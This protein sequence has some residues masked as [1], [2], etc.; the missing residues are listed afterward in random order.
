MLL[1]MR[2]KSRS[3]LASL[4][5]L[6]NTQFIFSLHIEY[7]ELPSISKLLISWKLDP[8]NSLSTSFNWC[9][10]GKTLSP[11]SVMQ[12]M[13]LEA[14]NDIFYNGTLHSLC[15]SKT[16]LLQSWPF[17]I[18]GRWAAGAKQHAVHYRG[19]PGKSGSRQFH[20]GSLCRGSG[21]SG[22]DVGQF[23]SGSKAVAASQSSC[24][25]HSEQSSPPQWS[26]AEGVSSKGC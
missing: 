10:V 20:R 21:C 8:M 13:P 11:K 14:K 3:T 19:G 26:R 9:D 6:S 24:L 22:A 1:R 4:V 25:V 17:G 2:Q 18:C 7:L 12:T 15:L 23:P 5:G 16:V